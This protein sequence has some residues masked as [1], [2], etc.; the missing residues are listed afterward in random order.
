MRSV[1]FGPE[2]KEE[3]HHV[4]L[5]KSQPKTE[6]DPLMKK[7]MEGRLLSANR[8]YDL[9]YP[10]GE[11]NHEEEEG[12][13]DDTLSVEEPKKPWE[14]ALEEDLD[15]EEGDLDDTL[16]YEE[17]KKPWEK[18]LEEIYWSIWCFLMAGLVTW[19]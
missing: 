3:S 5:V 2:A 10:S 17:P 9:S 12:D 7:K 18:E 1:S 6:Y 8:R 11:Q 13:L 19:N 14:E 16:P 15:E 4:V